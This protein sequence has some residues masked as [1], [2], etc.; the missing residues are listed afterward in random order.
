MVYRLKQIL[1]KGILSI[2][3]L[4]INVNS[5]KKKKSKTYAYYNSW[6]SVL[7]YE[8]LLWVLT[9][10]MCPQICILR[11]TRFSKGS[12]TARN[13]TLANVEKWTSMNAVWIK[14]VLPHTA[15]AHSHTQFNKNNSLSDIWLYYLFY[16]KIQS[17][18]FPSR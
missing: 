9:L 8:V 6:I 16:W 15:C 2:T 12:V 3:F 18:C 11:S 10:N 14:Y 4:E 7:V 17:A 1:L 13:F 5:I